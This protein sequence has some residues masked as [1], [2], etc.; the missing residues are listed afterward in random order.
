MRILIV[1]AGTEGDVRPHVALGQGLAADGHC[2]TLLTSGNFERLI[3]DAGLAFSPLNADFRQLMEEERERIGRKSAAVIVWRSLRRFGE[4]SRSWVEEARP[5][6][7]QADLIIG[8]AVGL[9]FGSVLAE[10]Y[11]VRFVR[12]TV[13]P[14]E[15]AREMPP[16]YVSLPQ[17]MPPVVN[18]FLYGALRRIW[19]QFAR[20]GQVRIRSALGLGPPSRFGPWSSPWLGR[21]P[22]LN[23]FSPHIVTPSVD[24][25]PHIATVGF[26]ILDQRE[27]PPSDALRDFVE[28]GPPPIVIG[29]GST[30]ARGQDRLASIV[31]DAIALSGHRAVVVGGWGELASRLEGQAGVFSTPR[32]PF[33]WLLPRTR[34][35]VHHGGI[36]TISAV[37]RAGLP[38]VSVPF[39]FDQFFWAHRLF[40]LGVAPRPL[41][42][43]RMTA[44]LLAEAIA[45]A[46]AP[47]MHENAQRLQ[48]SLR[49]EDGIANAIA[50]LRDWR[51]LE[52]A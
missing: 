48:E 28:Q 20:P 2:V 15:P 17:R 44:R 24:W 45:Q 4:L 9:Y 23:G 22:M 36:G 50:A 34:L 51:L 10:A 26:W 12:S 38:S 52:P 47:P 1:V 14:T 8:A 49:G 40:R 7:S 11:Q 29:F 31:G 25:G 35:A 18:R 3:R 43:T 41:D 5:A 19:W 6:A 21:A 39:M 32:A 13:I 37:L 46:D 16:P 27:E 33:D 42:Q 30:I